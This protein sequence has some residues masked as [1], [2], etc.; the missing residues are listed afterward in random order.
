VI[1][2]KDDVPTSS[3]PFVTIVLIA[4]NALVYVY[5]ISL[6]FDTCGPGAGA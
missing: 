4:L 2:L 6:A 5:Q 1:P 3:T